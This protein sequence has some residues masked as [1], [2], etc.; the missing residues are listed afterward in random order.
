MNGSKK[1]MYWL[2]RRLFRRCASTLAILGMISACG[3]S[4][5]AQAPQTQATQTVQGR[6]LQFH[7]NTPFIVRI[8]AGSGRTDICTLAPY[9]KEIVNSS[10][11]E[12]E[13]FYPVFEVPLTDSFSL[14]DMRAL[15][16]NFFYQIDDSGESQTIHIDSAPPFN[17]AASYIVLFNKSKTGGVSISRAASMRLS[18][19][20]VNDS[21]INTGESA[22][23]RINPKDNNDMRIVSP[24]N[25]QFPPITYRPG[26]RYTY[27]FDG[28]EITLTD[29]RPLD[30]IGQLSTVK[31]LTAEPEAVNQAL[32]DKLP[33]SKA[34]PY[35][36][37]ARLVLRE[38]GVVFAL[39]EADE[40]GGVGRQPHA[41]VSEALRQ[42][43]GEYTIRWELGPKDFDRA[44]GP[45]LTGYYD[46]T[47]KCYRV[48]GDLLEYDERRNLL[49][50]TYVLEIHPDSTGDAATIT[51]TD[52]LEGFILTSITGDAVDCYYV[53]GEEAQAEQSTATVF[54]YTGAGVL[55]WKA[56]IPL[57]RN[58]YYQDAVFNEDENQ[59]VLAGVS[60]GRD[61]AGTNGT[62][63]VQ[64]LDAETGREVWR[65][66]YTAQ[67]FTGVALVY[68]IAH[69][70][71][72]YGYQIA[73]CNI[74]SGNYAPPYIEATVNARGS[75]ITK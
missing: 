46:A 43:D 25:V 20:D 12:T 58:S 29:A 52:R 18:R 27:T 26:F 31:T 14:P 17:D 64:G 7:N 28:T 22:V 59:I 16:I 53:A 44:I 10:F 9:T 6:G 2:Q 74:V 55:K 41:Y 73:L 57:P 37:L 60:N 42:V 8:V 69:A 34:Y 30:K 39:G 51:R 65:T 24:M 63:F 75:F 45:A 62:P 71:N 70:P 15:D 11:G 40:R 33:A 67:E 3:T 5:P 36:R 50:G 49:P 32:A 4:N 1:T 19:L 21:N 56:Q 72:G 48:L 61:S 54:K 35:R 47:S 66:E 68:S 38:A 23:F 13:Y